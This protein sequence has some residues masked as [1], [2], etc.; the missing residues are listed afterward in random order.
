VL[1]AI[2]FVLALVGL[3]RLEGRLQDRSPR[4]R[5]RYDKITAPEY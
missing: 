5:L 2:L 4:P 3:Q 1:G